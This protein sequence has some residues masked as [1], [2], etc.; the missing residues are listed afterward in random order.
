MD[1]GFV[2]ALNQ[3]G[4]FPPHDPWLAG[5]D[6][7]YYYFGHLAMAL[8]VRLTD[9]EPSRGYNLSIALLFALTATATFTLAG[10]LWGA[11]RSALPELRRSPV[12]VGLVAVLAV[13]VLGNLAGGRELLQM[14]DL[15]A[16][17]MTG[18]PPRASCR[19]RSTSSPG[20][21]RLRPTCTR[22]CSRC[23]FTLLAAAFSVQ[24]ALFGPRARPRLRRCW[25]RSSRP[26][27][28]GCCTR[29]TRGRTRHGRACSRRRSC[30]GCAPGASQGE[31]LARGPLGAAR[32]R[33]EHRARA[34]V[35]PLLRP[36]LAAGFGLVPEPPCA[37]RLPVGSGAALRAVRARAR[38]D[39]LRGR[40]ARRQAR[41]NTI[42]RWR[43]A[44]RRRLAAR[45]GGRPRRRAGPHAP[46]R[47]SPS[48]WR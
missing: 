16:A 40:V 31:E 30:S 38:G 4:L 15:A 25:R 35:L 1:M 44:D 24:V 32:A 21:S 19:G 34:A 8:V 33:P 41:R 45:A 48:T 27:R 14:P 47:R 26:S 17:A 18:S 7:N 22:T 2:N 46:A 12:L 5:E 43:G 28:S 9:V 3:S 13:L 36:G 6:L 20:S 11:L 39:R 37:R 29:S 23:P 10:T 42:W